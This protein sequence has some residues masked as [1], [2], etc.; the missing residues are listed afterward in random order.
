MGVLDLVRQKLIDDGVATSAFPCWINYQPDQPDSSMVLALTGGFPQDTLG[1][2]NLPLTFQIKIRVG[3]LDFSDFEAHCNAVFECLQDADLSADSISLIQ[4]L[5][6][7][8]LTWNDDK[9]RVCGSF[10]FRVIQARSATG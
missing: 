6:S 9:N 5:A 8:P 1:N 10:N 2:E 7:G 3:T 4:A